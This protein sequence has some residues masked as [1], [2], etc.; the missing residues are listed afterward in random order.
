MSRPEPVEKENQQKGY[1]RTP[2]SR[3]QGQV[4]CTQ[5]GDEGVNQTI[6]LGPRRFILSAQDCSDKIVLVSLSDLN[7]SDV[8]G[9]DLL[10]DSVVQVNNSINVRSLGR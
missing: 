10:G 6:Q 5:P 1:Q 3:G 7:G 9:A 8:A 2:G 4:A